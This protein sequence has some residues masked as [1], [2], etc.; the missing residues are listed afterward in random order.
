MRNSAAS[1]DRRGPAGATDGAKAEY[2][3]GAKSGFPPQ[4]AGLLKRSGTNGRFF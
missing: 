4:K 3:Y 1:V 2:S